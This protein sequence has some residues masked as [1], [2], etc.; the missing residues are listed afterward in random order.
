MASALRKVRVRFNNGGSAAVLPHRMTTTNTALTTCASI[1][2]STKPSTSSSSRERAVWQ[3][4]V[5]GGLDRDAATSFHRPFKAAASTV[6]VHMCKYR[7]RPFSRQRKQWI[8]PPFV[9]TALHG[10]PNWRRST[11]CLAGHGGHNPYHR[12]WSLRRSRGRNDESNQ[13][14]WSRVGGSNG[15]RLLP[16]PKRDGDRGPARHG[17]R[18]PQFLPT[19]R[20]LGRWP[21][22][23]SK[24]SNVKG[25]LVS[26]FS[27]RPARRMRRTLRL[28]LSA[29]HI[30]IGCTCSFFGKATTQFT[31]R[32]YRLSCFLVRGARESSGVAV[33]VVVG[34]SETKWSFGL[35]ADE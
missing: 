12:C 16:S 8:A 15:G 26:S 30:S 3:K 20:V 24:N 1:G 11:A 34:D 13:Y 35:D 2:P 4:R 23:D 28:G 5:P 29:S 22:F 14:R 6:H 25:L 31:S 32:C 27:D 19:V 9:G 7:T 17:G 33:R 10:W 18:T 21:N